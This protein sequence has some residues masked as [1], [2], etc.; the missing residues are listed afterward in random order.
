MKRRDFIRAS[1]IAAP[2][3]S[4]F[5]ADLSFIERELRAGKL[6]KRSL[7]KTGEKLSIIGFGGIIVMDSTPE[8]ASGMVKKAI[9]AGVNYFDVAP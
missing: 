3:I 8:Y 9:D 6:E 5:P 1:A 2:A 7:G 4:L